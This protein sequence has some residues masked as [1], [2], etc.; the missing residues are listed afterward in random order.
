MREQPA[1]TRFR[2]RYWFLSNFYPAKVRYGDEVYP[3][4]EHA[5]QAAK[6]YDRKVR[7][8]IRR[9]NQPAAARAMGKEVVL[10]DGWDKKR[11]RVMLRLLRQKFEIPKLRKLLLETGDAYIWHYNEHGET[12][13]GVAISK[14]QRYA[15]A[16][17]NRLGQLI[18]QVRDEING[19]E[20]KKGQNGRRK[21]ACKGKGG[22]ATGPKRRVRIRASRVRLPRTARVRL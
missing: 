13:W 15:D 2:G 11:D 10:K 20:K 16:G 19:Q 18:M 4:V 14:F 21:K 6:T 1:I 9:C 17:S 22:T 5:Y 12:Y 8:H 3:S 7:K